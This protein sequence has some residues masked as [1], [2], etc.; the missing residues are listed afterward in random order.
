MYS[1][2]KSGAACNT[3]VAEYILRKKPRGDA[4]IDMEESPFLRDKLGD[5]L[6]SLAE[7]RRKQRGRAAAAAASAAAPVTLSATTAPAEI[8]MTEPTPSSKPDVVTGATADD[9]SELPGTL[10][11]DSSKKR[12]TAEGSGVDDYVDRAE[13][14]AGEARHPRTRVVGRSR[15]SSVK[16]GANKGDS[17]QDTR[18]RRRPNY[19]VPVDSGLPVGE[20]SS[21]TAHNS[22]RTRTGAKSGE[23]AGGVKLG[24]TQRHIM[25]SASLKTLSLREMEEQEESR[26]SGRGGDALDR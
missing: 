17:R 4:I 12:N 6:P 21:G 8:G 14:T 19:K 23:T 3:L 20:S 18:L 7:R 9:G 5:N 11:T 10:N 26:N 24:E 13:E 2:I 15:E 16:H 25:T 22:S 1:E